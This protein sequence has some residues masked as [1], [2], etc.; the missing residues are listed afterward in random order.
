MDLI[1]FGECMKRLIL[2]FMWSISLH[3][4]ADFVDIKAFTWG[5]SRETLAVTSALL[6]LSPMA[7]NGDF[8]LA[9]NHDQGY[10]AFYSLTLTEAD[11]LNIHYIIKSMAKNGWF[12]LLKKKFEMERCGD[13]VRHVHPL[14]FLGF[15]FGDPQRKHYMHMVK[16]SS[17]KWSRFK[18]GLFPNLQKEYETNGIYP[19]LAGFAK[20]VDV[21]KQLL[22]HY[23]E[24]QNWDGFLNAL[25]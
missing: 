5:D 15:I 13:A 21:D 20:L 3:P 25:F 18:G 7:S 23:I 8:Y 10:E 6:K 9:R 22:M 4:M 19:Y 24:N 14:R 1:L 11:G 2:A 12:T 17:I 16:K